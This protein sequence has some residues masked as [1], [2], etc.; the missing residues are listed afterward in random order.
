M[1]NQ[2]TKKNVDVEATPVV[3]HECDCETLKIELAKVKAELEQAN[4]TI[5]QYE[6]AYGELQIKYR[7]LYD[8]LG[9]QIE[10]TL[11]VK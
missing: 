7:R 11:S 8:I 1:T 10:Q 3:A 6:A 9:N 4:A 5:K 2:E